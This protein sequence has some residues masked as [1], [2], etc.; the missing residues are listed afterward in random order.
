MCFYGKTMLTCFKH[1]D[2]INNQIENLIIKKAK[3][4]FYGT[5][6]ALDVANELIDLGEVRLDLME[7]KEV[8]EIALSKLSAEDKMLLE[9]KYF[10]LL[11][12]IEDFD[13]TSRN[14]FRKQVRAIGRF[15]KALESL[16]YDEEWFLDN[17][18]KIPFIKGAYHKTINE[19]GK[20]HA[21]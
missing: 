1:I 17:Y 8:T 10:N 18:L 15:N 20:K 5:T 19:E 6:S 14:Y 7:L 13:H 16:G 12:S 11:P 21:K 9:Y 4:S 3:G 2:S